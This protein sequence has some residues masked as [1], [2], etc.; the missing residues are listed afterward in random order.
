VGWRRVTE[1]YGLPGN[2]A[3]AAA[4]IVATIILEGVGPLLLLL[5][6]TRIW[7][8]FVFVAF[9]G[10]LGLDL[11]ARYLNF[12]CVMFVF[13]FLFLAPET[14]EPVRTRL[15]RFMPGSVVARTWACFWLVLVVVVLV[16]PGAGSAR[17]SYVAARYFAFIVYALGMLAAFAMV[18]LRGRAL[19]K[20]AD[21]T[22]G[23]PPR[24]LAWLFPAL[25]LLN[26]V[27]PVLGIRNR[28][29]WQMY[30]NLR[31][32]PDASN[33]FLFPRSLDVLGLLRDRVDIL[34]TSDPDLA[35][36]YV[37]TGLGL[38]WI[39][40]R[41]EIASHPEASVR[42]RRGGREHDV[43][44]VASDPVL[45]TRPAWPARA[46]FFF[47]PLGATITERCGW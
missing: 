47:R 45:A 36:D 29:S 23:R 28:G 15:R 41:N 31:L 39:T 44:R 46:L 35:K 21:R 7:A 27:G 5:P 1:L 26:G 22:R 3:G 17:R 37:G 8:A 4:I 43:P 33:H 19:V 40:F 2:G 9:H 13:L 14:L 30:S 11:S 10:A 32:E 6:A 42:Y 20:R 38:P 25:V 18:L 24:A 16:V 12:S 34:A